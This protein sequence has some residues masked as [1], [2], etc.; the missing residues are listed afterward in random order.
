MI[1][2]K[3]KSDH[4]SPLY[5]ILQWLPLISLRKKPKALQRNTR[6]HKIWSPVLSDLTLYRSP[7]CSL[8]STHNGLLA[9]LKILQ[10]GSHVRAFPIAILSKRFYWHSSFRQLMVTPL[11]PSSVW[12]GIRTPLPLQSLHLMVHPTPNFAPFLFSIVLI[13]F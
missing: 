4:V 6:P 11:P 8:H 3:Y 10:A 5:K 9:H 13:T 1:F 12:E 2:L 7:L